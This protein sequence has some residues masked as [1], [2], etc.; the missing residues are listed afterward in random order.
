MKILAVSD[1]VVDWIYSPKIRLLLS[2]TDIAIGCGDLPSYYMEYIISSLDIPLFHVYGN[3]SIPEQK[4]ENDKYYQPGGVNLHRRV[5]RHNEVTFAGIEG[6]L[7]YRNGPFQYTQYE[8]WLHVFR[9]V[10][11]LL[12]NRLKF[13]RFLNVLITHAPPWGIHDQADLAHQ[14]IKAFLWMIST[15]QPDYHLH[16]HIHVYRPDTATETI[17]GK[18]KVINVFGFKKLDLS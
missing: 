18:T 4:G 5:I 8:M 7:K 1:I 16:G 9:L 11:A 3:H 15:F 17:W 2:D 10:P 14:G 12:L 6:S 13:G